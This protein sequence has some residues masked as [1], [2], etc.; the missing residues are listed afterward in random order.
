MATP[1]ASSDGAQTRRPVKQRNQTQRWARR[2]HTWT[3]MISLLIVLFFAITGITLNHPNW[4]FGQPP[5]SASVTG[6]VPDGAL[7]GSGSGTGIDLLAVSEYL[8]AE[9][10]V[11]GMVT[12]HRTSNTE[13]SISYRSPGYAADVRV[14]ADDGAFTLTTQSSGFVAIMNDLHKGRHTSTLW[15]WVI[16]ISAGLLV[17]ISLTGLILQTTIRLR[18]RTAFVLAGVGAVVSVVLIAISI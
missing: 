11:H 15:R 12:D 3:S 2:L 7:D 18:R 4:T 8:R 16:D 14:R 13:A 6:T 9:Q 5:V 1:T 10:G 17:L